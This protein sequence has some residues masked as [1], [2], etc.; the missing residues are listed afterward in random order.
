M[1]CGYVRSGANML[2]YFLSCSTTS[3]GLLK[4]P[5]SSLTHLRWTATSLPRLL[6]FPSRCSLV[7]QAVNKHYKRMFCGVALNF[8]LTTAY[9]YFKTSIRR[10]VYRAKNRALLTYRLIC[11]VLTVVGYSCINNYII[12]AKNI[13]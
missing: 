8:Y 12:L 9:R 2:G 1:F 13:H 4:N 5:L 11:K 10:Q 3:L 7:Q 6:S